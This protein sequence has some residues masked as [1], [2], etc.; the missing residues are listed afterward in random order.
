MRFHNLLLSVALLFSTLCSGQLPCLSNTQPPAP[1]CAQ[2]CFHCDFTGLTAS[3]GGYAP[4]P[5]PGFCSS[6][7]N[8][9]WIGLIAAQD[10]LT[11]TITPQGCAQGVEAAIYGECNAAA[12]LVCSAGGN[13]Q[14]SLNLVTVPG[15]RL[16]LMIDGKNGDVCNYTVTANNAA[17]PIL[18]T[19][20]PIMGSG[21]V[22]SGGK[23]TYTVPPVSGAS[24][25]I[26]DG[27]PGSTINGMAP[28]VTLEASVG[29]TVEIEFAGSSIFGLKSICVQPVN[30]CNVGT[31]ACYPIQILAPALTI[32]PSITVCAGDSIPCPCPLT[33]YRC[34]C[35]YQSSQGCDSTVVQFFIQKPPI[36]TFLPPIFLCPSDSFEVCGETFSQSGSYTKVCTD[37]SGCDS[38][39][40]F[41]IIKAPISQYNTLF[42]VK[43]DTVCLTPNNPSLTINA[44]PIPGGIYTWSLNGN[45]LS[46][47][48][49]SVII[50]QPGELRLCINQQFGCI[51]C[52]T[53]QIVAGQLIPGMNS[54]MA[55]NMV[56][57]SEQFTLSTPPLAGATE[58]L[59]ELPYGFEQVG[60]GTN[61]TVRPINILSVVGDQQ[62]CVTPA[63]GCNQA[64]KSCTT[65]QVTDG[66]HRWYTMQKN[67][68]DTFQY[69]CGHWNYEQ[70]PTHVHQDTAGC[71]TLVYISFSLNPLT[72]IN[73]GTKTI[74]QGDTLY[75]AP[76]SY[77][78]PGTYIDTLYD[79]LT[80]CATAIRTFTVVIAQPVAD[81]ENVADGDSICLS[82]NQPLVAVD[83][84]ASYSWSDVM[85]NTLSTERF[86]LPPAPGLYY[87]YASVPSDGSTCTSVDSVSVLTVDFP[88]HM[89]QQFVDCSS[90]TST[91]SVTPYSPA[92]YN[93]TWLNER[94]DTVG[95]GQQIQVDT[96]GTYTVLV[97]TGNCVARYST[98]VNLSPAIGITLQWLT[99]YVDMDEDCAVTPGDLK[100]SN[101]PIHAIKIGGDTITRISN[102]QGRV[103]FP[104]TEGTYNIGVG[105]PPSNNALTCPLQLVIPECSLG[106]I[107]DTAFLR[108]TVSAQEPAW[109]KSKLTINPNPASHAIQVSGEIFAVGDIINWEIINDL[110]VVLRSETKDTYPLQLDVTGLSSGVYMLTLQSEDKAAFGKFLIVH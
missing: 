58:Y 45:L 95:V 87:L 80:N 62:F 33:N 7:E 16:L 77:T 69:A 10:A 89:V 94:Q 61:I 93:Y 83:N 81:I 25:Y 82:A 48:S 9:S 20:Q 107:S 40:H 75:L 56:C 21:I 59:W 76:Y 2:V 63:D 91:L 14:F 11:V 31:L 35:I 96:S 28:P 110:G 102:A 52:D 38:T 88:M 42:T 105:Q 17:A 60:N 34:E 109:H 50:N 86:F 103:Q 70:P 39:V 71:D 37:A 19:T 24:Q 27:P 65:I 22:C 73:L 84:A 51:A 72:L 90:L 36:L 15:Q 101:L 43:A 26:W 64:L 92:L 55:P 1:T 99:L 54:I 74:C 78:M 68:L 46:S 106:T 104:L 12:P 5:A 32:L 53:I 3:T 85:G 49:G 100:A 30:A 66:I 57:A 79:A 44:T 6:I 67:C 98:Q 97:Q 13:T 29:T 41:A 23:A 4:Q 18:Q 108:M 8:N 47:N